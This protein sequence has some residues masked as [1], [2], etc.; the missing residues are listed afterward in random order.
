M[1][2]A[3]SFPAARLVPTVGFPEIDGSSAAMRALKHDMLCVARDHDVTVVIAG[4]SG[5][6]KE[7]VARA[8]HRASP[9]AHMPFLV[10]DCAGLSPTLAEDTLFGHVRGAF[11]GAVDECAGPFER[12]DGGT[13]LLDEIGDLPL[14]LQTK[15]LRALQSRTVQRLG[16]RHETAFDVRILAATHVDL[17]AAVAAC[18][19]R[20]DLYYRLTVYEI[21]VPPLRSRGADDVRELAAAILRRL[22]SRRGRAVP[23]IDASV[24]QGLGERR[25]PGNVRELE[26]VLERMLVA[27]GEAP[28][29]TVGHLP[30]RSAGA[31]AAT[32]HS[33]RAPPLADAIED[34][35]VRSGF[36]AGGAAAALGLSRHQLYRL[37]R[38]YGIR[39]KGGD[40]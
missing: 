27:A 19:F 15:L 12:A 9:R 17:A 26:N 29:L 37:V 25:W 8:I 20:E 22:A 7:R 1:R 36:S 35:L 5:T 28:M 39:V 33:R 18:R 2:S 13:I 10:V 16:A 38:R 3:R 14:D 31:A 24:M 30:R 11:T 40:R 32:A 23:A 34:A 6:G 21:V 4:E